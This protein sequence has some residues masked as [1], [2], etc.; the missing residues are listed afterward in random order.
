MPVQ[1]IYSENLQ[2]NCLLVGVIGVIGVIG[3]FGVFGVFGVDSQL[4]PARR[5]ASCI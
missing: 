2:F 4:F 5:R 3:V 1:P